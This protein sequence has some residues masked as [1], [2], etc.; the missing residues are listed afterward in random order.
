M[1]EVVKKKLGRPFSNNPANVAVNFRLTK[2]QHQKYVVMGG[3][4]ALKKFI[5][6]TANAQTL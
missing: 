6:E 4:A 5:D 2:E 3:A 1:T